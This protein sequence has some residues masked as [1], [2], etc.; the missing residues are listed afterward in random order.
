MTTGT[1]DIPS[2][3]LNH[4]YV[5]K[6]LAPPALGASRPGSSPSPFPFSSNNFAIDGSSSHDVMAIHAFR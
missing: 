4:A 1:L 6:M 2:A 3:G 5:R